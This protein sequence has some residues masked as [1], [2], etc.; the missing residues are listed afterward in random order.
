MIGI[1][2][3]HSPGWLLIVFFL[4]PA[5]AAGQHF[6]GRETDFI[7]SLSA[8][9][10][11]EGIAATIVTTNLYPCA[12]YRL[13]AYTTREMDTITVHNN[14]MVRPVPCVQGGDAATGNTFLG[15]LADGVYF[16]RITYRGE[17]DVHRISIRGNHAK[18]GG[19]DARLSRVRGF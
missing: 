19:S 14:G 9:S 12:G 4:I 1:P 13:R 10:A 2:H 16:L 5:F 8:V 3:R 18:I 7:I 17:S 6:G 15:D 11:P